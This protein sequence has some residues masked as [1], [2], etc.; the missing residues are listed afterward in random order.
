MAINMSQCPWG[1][2]KEPDCLLLII[3]STDPNFPG[4]SKYGERESGIRR[5]EEKEE[6]AVICEWSRY[7]CAL[8]NVPRSV[9]SKFMWKHAGRTQKGSVA[10]RS[11]EDSKVQVL[12]VT[13]SNTWH[14]EGRTGEL[15]TWVEKAKL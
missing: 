12:N 7:L 4:K 6:K 13:D 2:E 10:G 9:Q 1:F 11:Q 14:L 3:W 15:L 8:S 5:A